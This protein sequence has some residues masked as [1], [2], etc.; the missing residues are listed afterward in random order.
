MLQFPWG[1]VR[2][3][4]WIFPVGHIIQ[5]TN[6]NYN[7]NKV[8]KGTTWTRIKDRFLLSAGDTYSAGSTGGEAAHTLNTDEIPSH[9][10]ELKQ[11][12]NAGTIYIDPY[13]ASDPSGS[14]GAVLQIKTY[15]YLSDYSWGGKLIN[16]SSGGGK[17]HNN[18]PP[19]LTVYTWQRIS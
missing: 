19:Y 7:P 18:M 14:Y 9:T 2:I 10:H 8:F 4:D 1:G 5:T 12:G 6:S 11:D 16:R 17:P 15:G 13:Y 3:I